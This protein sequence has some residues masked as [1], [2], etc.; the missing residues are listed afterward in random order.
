MKIEDIKKILYDIVHNSLFVS[1]T[2]SS[3]DKEK[4]DEIYNYFIDNRNAIDDLRTILSLRNN[5]TK[6]AYDKYIR[7]ILINVNTD[8]KL[9]I[10]NN[11]T[12]YEDIIK[13]NN[14]YI[15]IWLSLTIDERI[16]Y[17][18]NIRI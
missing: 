5:D 15:D 18:K 10:L 4:L 7:N 3:E 6:D 2:P 14:I 16:S 13:N 1:S 9:D 17:L 8:I 11:Q 12:N